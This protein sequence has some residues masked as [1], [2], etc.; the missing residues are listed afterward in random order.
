M[1]EGVTKKGEKIKI[2][3]RSNGLFRVVIL[4]TNYKQ[5]RSV[6]GWKLC[7]PFKAS[8]SETQR[9]DNGVDFNEAKVLFDKRAA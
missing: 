5:G 6:S 8:Y 3:K 1:V 7:T 4:K 2:I 9:Y